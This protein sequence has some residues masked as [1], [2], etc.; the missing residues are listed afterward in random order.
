M[1]DRL[2]FFPDCS[3]GVQKGSKMKRQRKTDFL[4]ISFKILDDYLHQD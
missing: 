3:L 1:H 2:F 4:E